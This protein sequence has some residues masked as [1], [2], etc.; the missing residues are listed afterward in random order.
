LWVRYSLILAAATLAVALFR[1]GMNQIFDGYQNPTWHLSLL[2]APIFGLEW[3]ILTSVFTMVALRDGLFRTS[4]FSFQLSAPS[5]PLAKNDA[6]RLL[7]ARVR[8]AG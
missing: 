4:M 6:E 5:N 2:R 3:F 7:V 1:L 8:V